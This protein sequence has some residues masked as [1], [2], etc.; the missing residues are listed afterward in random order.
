MQTYK[1]NKCS[2]E[3]ACGDCK[4]ILAIFKSLIDQYAKKHHLEI[5]GYLAKRESEDMRRRVQR[6]MIF[7]KVKKGEIKNVLCVS[8]D[9]L[10]QDPDELE[11]FISMFKKYGVKVYTLK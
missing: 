4:E 3:N 11:S 1:C 9:R 7:S 2:I 10:S 8:S 6:G 5:T